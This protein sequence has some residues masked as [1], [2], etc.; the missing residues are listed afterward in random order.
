MNDH[1][2][3]T[4]RAARAV[5]AVQVGCR[6]GGPSAC[7]HCWYDASGGERADAWMAARAALAAA[8][9]HEAPPT[10]GEWLRDED[11]EIIRA[12]ESALFGVTMARGRG[13][14]ISDQAETVRVLAALR[15]AVRGSDAAA[16]GENT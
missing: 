8:G 9:V 10:A 11:G 7:I 1:D 16:P 6:C 13:D 4:D 5:L 14:K 12:I 2:E 3:A 15:L